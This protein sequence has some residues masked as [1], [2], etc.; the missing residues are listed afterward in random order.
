MRKNIIFQIIKGMG[1]I[2]YSSATKRTYGWKGHG[3][4]D[5]R[6]R[7]HDFKRAEND[8]ALPAKVDFRQDCPPI[9]DQGNLGSC[10]AQ[11]AGGAMQYT[12]MKLK[13]PD[14][15]IRSRLFIY[16]NSRAAEGTIYTDSG[17]TIRDTMKVC[18][19]MGSPVEST[20]PYN[21]SY[22]TYQPPQK[23]YDDGV[24]CRISEYRRVRQDLNQLKQCLAQ[25]TPIVCGVLVYS[26]FESPDAT[27]TGK[28]PMPGQNE[29]VLGGH[30]IMLVGY[31]DSINSFIFRNSWN[32]SWGASGYGFIP[33]DYIVSPALADEFWTLTIVTEDPNAKPNLKAEQKIITEAKTEAEAEGIKMEIMDI[34]PE[35][36]LDVKADVKIEQEKT[37]PTKEASKVESEKTQTVKEVPKAVAK[38]PVKK[39]NA[40]QLNIVSPPRPVPNNAHTASSAAKACPPQK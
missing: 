38:L 1:N 14:T 37:Q 8:P 18:A 36:K 13:L 25:N 10:T 12:M 7:F 11:A 15:S 17:A 27:K 6:D 21:I 34:K 9:Y 2:I 39:S 5:A 19:K 29:E 40:R 23:A 20:W 32:I 28:I 24:K 26:S 30:A 33:Y 3:K 35:A 16:Y 22:F 4:R 31:D